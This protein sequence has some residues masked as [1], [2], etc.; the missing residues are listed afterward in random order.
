[1]E[2]QYTNS[3]YD[4]A[5][6]GETA[7]ALMANGCVIIGQHADSTRRSLR[8]PGAEGCRLRGLLRGL[9]HRHALRGSPPRP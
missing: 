8:R 3:W 4:P 9:Q 5:A 7:N 6:E 1:M 2:V